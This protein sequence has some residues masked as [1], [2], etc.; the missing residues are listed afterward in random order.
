MEDV[1]DVV[2]QYGGL[3]KEHMQA[4]DASGDETKMAI[5]DL[6]PRA[7]R[8]PS[9]YVNQN[10]YHELVQERA[11]GIM[12]KYQNLRDLI[13]YWEDDHVTK[14]ENKK[15]VSDAQSTIDNFIVME[16]H[17]ELIGEMIEA[18]KSRPPLEVEPETARNIHREHIAVLERF[19]RYAEG[20]HEGFIEMKSGFEICLSAAKKLHLYECALGHVEDGPIHRGA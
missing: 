13:D 17:P 5:S 11:Q 14:L 3:I 7:W 16:Q 19:K 2:A 4:L 1:S 15:M 6:Y 8:S 12:L 10:F 18:I 9:M 20:R